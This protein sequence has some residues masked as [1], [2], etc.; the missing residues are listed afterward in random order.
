MLEAIFQADPT[1][2]MTIFLAP[3]RTDLRVAVDEEES[4]HVS[5]SGFITSFDDANR[6][7]T[8]LR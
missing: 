2:A 1:A 3:W 5:F 6:P 4:S 7:T 8:R